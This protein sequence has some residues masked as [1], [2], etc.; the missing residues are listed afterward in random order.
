MQSQAVPLIRAESPAVGTGVE[1][2]VITD[3]GTS[4]VSNVTGKVTYV[5]ARN[6]QITLV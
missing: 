6:I 5:D 4:V 3:S 2:R 1:E